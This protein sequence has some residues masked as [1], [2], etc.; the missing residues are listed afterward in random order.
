M[1]SSSYNV[2]RNQILHGK[3]VKKSKFQMKKQKSGEVFECEGVFKI[4]SLKTDRQTD[5]QRERERQ[6]DRQRQ[7]ETKRQ[8]CTQKGQK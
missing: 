3:K 4:G 6:T 1:S 5:I 8:K 7:T 2:G